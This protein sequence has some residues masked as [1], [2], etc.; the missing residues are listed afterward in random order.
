M[1]AVVV[2]AK[3]IDVQGA[4]TILPAMKIMPGFV[5]AEWVA[6]NDGYGLGIANFESEDQ[7]KAMVDRLNAENVGGVLEVQSAGIGE[8]LQHV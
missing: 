8:V 6:M 1:Y 4:S 7:A 3:A 2:Q 5:S